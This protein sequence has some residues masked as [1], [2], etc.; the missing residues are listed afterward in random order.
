MSV[1]VTS[2]VHAEPL[3]LSSVT[4]LMMTVMDV[5]MSVSITVDRGKGAMKVSV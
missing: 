3:P 1:S 2:V 4:I 5:S